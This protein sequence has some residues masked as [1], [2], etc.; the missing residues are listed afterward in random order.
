VQIDFANLKR[1]YKLMENEIKE[2]IDKILNS[3]RFILGKEVEELENR[4]KD[5]TGSKFCLCVSSGTDALLISLLSLNIGPDDEIIVPSF[6]FISTAEVVAL[7]GAKPVFVDIDERTYNIDIRKIEEKITEKTK[8]IIPVSLF[9]QPADFDEINEIAKRYDLIVIED[10]AQS[11][12]AEYKEKKSCNLSDIGCTSFFPAKPL[13]CYGDGGAIFTNDDEIY[14]KIKA[15]RVHGQIKRYQHK[16]IGVNGRLDTLQAGILLVKLKYFKKE[17][18]LRNYIARKYLELLKDNDKII[19]PFIK[20]DRL[21]VWAQFSI[22]IKNREKIRK[23][24]QEKGIPTAIH[25]PVPLHLQEC[26]SYLGYKKGDLPVSEKVA[27]EILSLPMNP[28]LTEEEI[29]YIAENL[30]KATLTS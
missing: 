9:G 24:L 10:G 15:I 1:Q 30:I 3:C 19:L 23:Y 14:E 5:F 22:R 8:A 18:E 20:E 16:F 4:L 25:Y 29:E 2:N 6:T 7:L 26:F 28:Y 13:G 21:S 11:F 17:I 27:E 12:G